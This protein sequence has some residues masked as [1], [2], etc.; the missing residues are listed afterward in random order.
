[1]YKVLW[2]KKQATRIYCI[3]QGIQPIAY[4]NFNEVEC[5]ILETNIV[6]QL[7]HKNKTLQHVKKVLRDA[8]QCDEFHYIS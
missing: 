2:I 8:V 1:M 7:Q 4:N 3:E 6:N 5:Y